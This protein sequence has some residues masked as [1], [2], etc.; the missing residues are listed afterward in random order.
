MFTLGVMY[1]DG[2][3]VLQDDIE[4]YLWMS[5]AADR[6]TGENQKTAEEARDR[7]AA[8]MTPARIAEAQ[9][10]AAESRRK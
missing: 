7:L 1:R 4:A 5:L 3:L 2:Q 10:L 8:L 9:T 6:L